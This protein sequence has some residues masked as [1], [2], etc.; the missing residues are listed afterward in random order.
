MSHCHHHIIIRVYHK[1]CAHSLFCF[2]REI[3]VSMNLRK[4]SCYRGGGS[5]FLSLQI[6]S[7]RYEP[8]YQTLFLL[9]S[10]SN[11]RQCV[12]SQRSTIHKKKREYSG[13]ETCG[14]E[15]QLE[16]KA[17]PAALTIAAPLPLICIT[18]NSWRKT[19]TI[20]QKS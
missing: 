4:Y 13:Q 2:P 3:D 20:E 10:F 14:G 8:C 17:H 16:G 12:I 18:P 6:C 7:G 5:N 1:F 11:A 15:G 9:S 19:K